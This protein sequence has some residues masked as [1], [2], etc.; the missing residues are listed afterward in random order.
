MTPTG[1]VTPSPGIPLPEREPLPPTEVPFARR[2]DRRAALFL[3]LFAFLLASFPARNGDLWGHLAAGRAAFTTFR[4]E[5]TWLYDLLGYGLYTAL[6]GPALV[7]CKALLVVGLA[8]VLLRLSRSGPGWWIAAACTALT[9]LAMSMRFLLQPVTVSYLF[10]ALTLWFLQ[11]QTDGGRE[12]KPGGPLRDWLPPWPLLVLFVVWVNVDPWFVLGLALVALVGLGR[13]L[14]QVSRGHQLHLGFLVSWLL[15]AAACLLNPAHVGAFALP[16]ELGMPG[17]RV[18]AGLATSP[19]Q[20]AYLTTFGLRPAALA[21][22]PLLGLG[23]HSFLLNY[24]RWRWQRFLPWLALALLSAFQVRAIPFFA[25][26]AGPVLA[27]N[28]QEYFA[29]LRDET[30]HALRDWQPGVEL[31]TPQL[32]LALLATAWPGWLQ[33]PPFEPRRWAIETSPS[34]ERGATAVRDWY[35]SDKLGPD[36]RGLHL[37][38]ETVTAFAWFCP[39]EKS[40]R[41]DRLAATFREE[42]AAPEDRDQQLRGLGINHVVVHDPDPGRLSALVEPLLADPERWPLLELDGD[43][44]I[45]GW[46]DPAMTHPKSEIRNPQSH[47]PFRDWPAGLDRLAFREPGVRRAP[48]QAPPEGRQWWEVFWKPAPPPAVDRVEAQVCLTHAEELRQSAPIR[49][50]ISW[51]SSQAA[52]LVGAASGWTGPGSLFSAYWHLVLLQPRVLEP[53]AAPDRMLALDRG[54]LELQ[55]RY[56]FQRDDVPPAVLYLAVRAARRAVAANPDDAQA[57]QVLG[58]SYLRLLYSTRERVWKQR[59]PELL[60]LRRAQASAAL[61]RAI[62]LKPT[63][64]QAHLS[65]YGLYTEIGYLDLALEHL[66]TYLKLTRKAGPP[67]GVALEAFRDQEAR[68]QE[69]YQRLSEV[70]KDREN[71]YEVAAAGKTVQDRALLAAAK[72]LAGK[73]RDMLLE[74]DIAAFGAPGLELELKLLLGTGRPKNVA[75]WISPEH[76][77]VLGAPAYHWLRA[78]ALAATGDYDQAEEECAELGR[79]LTPGQPGKEGVRPRQ[80]MDLLIGQMVLDQ[81]SGS[82]GLPSLLR[83]TFGMVEFRERIAGLTGSLRQEAD[84]TVLRGLLALEQGNVEEAAVAFRVALAVWQDEAT[85]VAGGGLDFGGRPVAQGYLEWL[86]QDG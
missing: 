22:F 14:D 29:G 46:R 41:D 34:L 59:L 82:G 55:R 86:E 45:F 8:L 19:F 62:A 75:D 39:Q 70:V 73:A 67:A 18:A 25:V 7:V 61:N 69:E 31:L 74:S 78:Q 23:L 51:Q 33:A 42:Q 30:R 85:A 77:A 57:Y 35:Q 40:V 58:E 32:A 54:T 20:R 53:G 15:L 56:T 66:G 72:G 28:L 9:L 44:A 21:Y 24:S 6:G 68:L 63:L 49:H 13:A 1:D 27:W 81:G 79:V 2:L 36:A 76:Q 80:M 65:L 71:T 11:P 60:Q 52:A 43:L 38:A 16:P 50:L 17:G 64:A 26:V 10:L 83:R 48:G 3:A 37:S 12:Q 47:D 84:A 5:P 4:L